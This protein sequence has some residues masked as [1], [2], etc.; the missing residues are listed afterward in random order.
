MTCGIEFP[1]RNP[2]IG[3]GDLII[4][5]EE[6]YLYPIKDTN[7]KVTE[8]KATLHKKANKFYCLQK[9]CLIKR[10]PYFWKGLLTIYVETKAVLVQEHLD[11]LF[12]RLHYKFT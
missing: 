6:R 3:E 2:K 10:H 8:M 4:R 7:G 11:V 1:K 9:K 5:H 12:Q